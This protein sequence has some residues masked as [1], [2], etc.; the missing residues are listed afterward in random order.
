MPPLARA[1]LR[2][3]KFVAA[4]ACLREALE[5]GLTERELSRELRE[6]D[7]TLGPAL[8]AWKAKIVEASGKAP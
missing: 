7:A 5:A 2:R 6:I 1:F 8:T 4:Y 3:K